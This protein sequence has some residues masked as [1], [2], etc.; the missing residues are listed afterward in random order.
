MM[1]Q[2]SVCLFAFFCATAQPDTARNLNEQG[3]AAYRRGDTATA[4]HLY[5]EAI[6]KWQ[7]MG[8]GFHAHLAITRMNLAD[9]LA[10]QGKRVDAASQLEQSL[11]LFRQ[12]LGVRDWRTLECMNTLAALDLIMGDTE[13]AGALVN[14]A[15]PLERELFPADARTATTL[16]E[17]A[18]L[19]LRTGH[20]SEAM[21][22][23]EEALA[24]ATKAAGEDSLNAALAYTVVGEVYRVGDQPG[25]ALPVYRRA[26]DIYEKR[27]GPQHP[28]VAALLGQEGLL[29]AGEGKLA[30]AAQQIQRALA[31]L[32][33][34]CPNCDYERWTL[35]SNLAQVRVRQGMYAEAER[36]LE[37]AVA[38]SERGQAQST[39]ITELRQALDDVRAKERGQDSQRLDR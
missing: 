4:E 25:R 38:L 19:K 34:S 23:A 28:R 33:H 6:T 27:L 15:L 10:A 7:E 37:A 24:L 12:S 29:L 20:V 32:D 14:E 26:R 17:L 8:E 22:P 21:A 3:L 1:K 31:M 2:I 11:A 39:E 13:H 5:R 16:T 9:A 30:T 36:L 35:D 18:T